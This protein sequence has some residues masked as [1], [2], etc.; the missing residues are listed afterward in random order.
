MYDRTFTPKTP[1]DIVVANPDQ[2]VLLKDIISGKLRFPAHGKCG[3]ILYGSYG[4]GKSTLAKLIPEW[5]EQARG[6][7]VPFVDVIEAKD[8]ADGRKIVSRIN[9]GVN[10]AKM[11][12]SRLY[13]IVLDEADSFERKAQSSLRGIM[14]KGE[15]AFVLTTNDLNSIDSGVQSRSYRI[16]MNAAPPARWLPQVKALITERGAVVPPD[17]NL[18]EVIDSCNGSVRE[19]MNAAEMISS[20]TLA[21]ALAA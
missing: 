2:E 3:I 21:V 15:A 10:F 13:Y 4:T 16:D 9:N 7:D 18:I 6:G 8:Y 1:D 12:A 17:E 14:D 20:M 5:M 19:I 11:T